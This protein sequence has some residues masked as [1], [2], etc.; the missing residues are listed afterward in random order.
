MILILMIKTSCRSTPSHSPHSWSTPG[1]NTGKWSYQHFLPC[2]GSFVASDLRCIDRRMSIDFVF[3]FS[4]TRI[5]VTPAAD[6]PCPWS[7][8]LFSGILCSWL[9]PW[10]F[11]WRSIRCWVWMCFFWFCVRRWGKVRNWGCFGRGAGWYRPR[12]RSERWRWCWNLPVAGAG[13]DVGVLGLDG[14]D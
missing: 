1:V 9:P 13:V 4:C 3:G 10:I 14:I 6:V 11:D 2:G 12:R 5:S 7:S 8:L